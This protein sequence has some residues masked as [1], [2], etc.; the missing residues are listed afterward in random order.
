MADHTDK[1]RL[2]PLF[3]LHPRL[4]SISIWMYAVDVKFNG[5]R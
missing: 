1:I 2:I 4:T 3:P 5:R